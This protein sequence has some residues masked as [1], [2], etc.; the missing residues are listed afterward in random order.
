MNLCGLDVLTFQFDRYGGGFVIEIAR[1]SQEG[2]LTSWGKQIP[3]SKVT[4]WDLPSSWRH[5]IQPREGGGTDSW[6]RFDN[7][8]VPKA[9]ADV[10]CLL[11]TVDAWFQAEAQ[12]FS[13]ADRPKA[14]HSDA[15]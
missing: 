10:L 6:F 2:F 5:R 11:P 9:V 1:C 15:N 3:P 14:A 13:Q 12:Q 4:T 8:K 7:E